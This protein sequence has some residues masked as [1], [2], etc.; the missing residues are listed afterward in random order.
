M[1]VRARIRERERERENERT[2]KSKLILYVGRYVI[3]CKEFFSQRVISTVATNVFDVP[4][5][6]TPVNMSFKT[7]RRVTCLLQELVPRGG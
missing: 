2:R 5:K 4:L 7:K 1:C 3:Y 6:R